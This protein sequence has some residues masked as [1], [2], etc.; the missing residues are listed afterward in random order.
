MSSQAEL[1][2]LRKDVQGLH[3]KIAVESSK[4]ASAREKE[5][6]NRERAPR[7]S[8]STSAASRIKEADRQAKSAVAAEKRRADLEKKLA[9]KQK[10]LHIAEARLG[11]K[12]D[13][14]QKRAIKQLQSRATAAEH[15]FRPVRTGILGAVPG[16][17]PSSV[18]DVFIS[19]AS[20][21]KEAVARPL[22]EL[23]IERGV[24]VWYD[25]FTLTVGDG[26][27]RSIDRGLAGSRFGVIILSPDFFRKEWPQAELDGLV[28]KQ[29]ASGAKVILP[30]WHRL[31]KDDV[32]GASPTLA[33]LKALNT[34]VM[35][36][37]EIAD[38]IATVAKAT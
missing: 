3:Q 23:L 28:A 9:A 13:E 10:S 11:R 33:D 17:T 25:D 36:L 16:D 1:D 20:E 4:V 32:L 26:L 27:R 7:A 22:A 35:T 18:Y 14:E 21:D 5:A 31:T 29:R 34:G 30:I 15:Q 12:Q 8:T 19:H 6:S 2:R 37:V 24:N 38:E